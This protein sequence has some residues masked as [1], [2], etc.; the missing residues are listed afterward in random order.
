VKVK[1]ESATHALK[2]NTNITEINKMKSYTRA[3]SSFISIN[4]DRSLLVNKT[5][6]LSQGAGT[7]ANVQ[8]IPCCYGI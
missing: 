7:Y 2:T 5:N 6:S 1:S 3:F 4:K 8:V